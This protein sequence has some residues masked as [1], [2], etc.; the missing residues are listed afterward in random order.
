MQTKRTQLALLALILAGSAQAADGDKLDFTFGGFGTLGAT[1]SNTDNAQFVATTAQ[2]SGADKS[3]DLGVDTKLGLQGTL[4]LGQQLSGTA[5]VLAKRNADDDFTP[6]LEW[7]F[8]KYAPMSGL[9]LRAG[10]MGTP[11]FLVSDYRDVG[12]STPWMRPPVEVYGSVPVSH[13]DGIDAL[14]RKSLGDTVLSAQAL[15]GKARQDL[16]VSGSKAE[17]EVD[18]LTGLSLTAEHG[19]FTLRGAYFTGKLSLRA[20]GAAQ[21]VGA[22]RA[23]APLF[24]P[25]AALAGDIEIADDRVTFAGLGAMYDDGGW[26]LQGEYTRVR[27]DGDG[28]ANWDASY[29]TAGRRFGAWLPTLTWSTATPKATLTNTI[30]AAGLLAPLSAGVSQFIRAASYDQTT[31]SFALRY[32]VYK[33]IAIKAQYDRVDADPASN[34]LTAEKPGFDGRANLISVGVD[35]VF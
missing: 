17:V 4:R 34:L 16:A 29:L 35:F 12:Y 24:A 26:L 32:D 19:S 3:V 18:K 30:P 6:A 8:V 2:A 33:N 7:G 28:Q 1:R 5:Q 23:A 14:Y 22:L 20:T 15:F 13:F 25:A 10:R 31:L 21:L 9:S 11:L 27:A